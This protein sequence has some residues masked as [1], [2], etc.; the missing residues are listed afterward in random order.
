MA[1]VVISGYPASGKSTRAEQMKTDYERR[2]RE[3]DGVVDGIREVVIINDI[4]Y[5]GRKPYD[6][7]LT[8]K[9]AR[10]HVFTQVTRMLSP[11][12]LVILDGLNYIKGF[13]YQLW[14]AAR[15]ARVRQATCYVAA[16]E[17]VCR[18][19]EATKNEEDR[20]KPETLDNLF[21]R[22]EEPS[23]MV[24]WDSPLFSLAWDDDV[25]NEST[26]GEV[27]GE[28]VAEVRRNT[29]LDDIWAAV[30][31]GAKKGPT[32]A[33][34]Q[35]TKPPPDALQVLTKT[36]SSL[37]TALQTHLAM[38]PSPSPAFPLLTTSSTSKPKSKSS[39]EKFLIHLPPRAVSPSELQRLKRQFEGIQ[40]RA[41][42]SGGTGAREGTWTEEAI[43]ERFARY[44]MECWGSSIH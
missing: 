35:A 34:A 39:G 19:F 33:V 38:N 12:R 36:T 18:R 27:Q 26:S 20:Y 3:N 22:F 11:S 40:K 10:A 2:I 21:M 42:V 25:L 9:P 29:T 17:E 37:L 43:A 28:S 24:R 44:L 16:P 7:S 13:R 41:L 4:D 6:N 5:D 23:S 32:A 15:E 8:E 31:T 14:C 30:T 1:L